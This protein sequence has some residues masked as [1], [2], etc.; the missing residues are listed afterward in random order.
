MLLLLLCV[1]FSFICGFF[2]AYSI[3]TESGEAAK[4]KYPSLSIAHDRYYSLASLVLLV[5]FPP[6]NLSSV[7]TGKRD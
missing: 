7:D 4:A 1:L 2:L 3:E 6:Q 5:F